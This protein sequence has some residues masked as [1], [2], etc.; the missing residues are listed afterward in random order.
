MSP[1]LTPSGGGGSGGDLVTK[2]CLILCDPMDCSPPGSSVHGISQAR[3]LERVAIS[4][5]PG[6][7]QT[8]ALFKC[9]LFSEAS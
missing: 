5:S 1:S 6:S 8:V 2:R 3:I 4:F 7:V 9:H